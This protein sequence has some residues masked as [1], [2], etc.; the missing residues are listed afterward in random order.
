MK[1]NILEKVT[2]FLYIWGNFWSKTYFYKKV[3][4]ATKLVSICPQEMKL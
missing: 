1:P 3:K 4:D 2:I